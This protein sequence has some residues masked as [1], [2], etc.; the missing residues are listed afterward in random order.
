M[1]F[2]PEEALELFHLLLREVVRMLCAGLIHG[3]L[4]DFNVLLGVDGPVVI[5]FPQA[6]DAAANQSA[7]QL[8]VRDVD[9]LQRF[10]G[11]WSPGLKRKRYG[12]EMWAL[13]QSGELHPD[14]PLTGHYR[15]QRRQADTDAV[16]REIAAAED[17]NR[18]RLGL[19]PVQ[20]AN[21]PPQVAAK[22]KPKGKSSRRT[23][24]AA[25]KA[26]RAAEKYEALLEKRRAPPP[27]IEI[28][29]EPTSSKKKKRQRR[30][31]RKPEAQAPV[32]VDPFDDLDALLS[33]DD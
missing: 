5:D 30:R 31:K 24:A 2:E 20:R 22:A 8:L 21:P 11:R 7:R 13:Y 9:N 3:D 32:E 6:V 1:R 16:L 15:G 29:T 4:S 14:T 19:D 12:E 27:P 17:E 26:K 23:E 33:S 25:L 10:L 28:E 18:R